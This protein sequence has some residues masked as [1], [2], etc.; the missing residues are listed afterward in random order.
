MTVKAPM[1]SSEFFDTVAFSLNRA[2]MVVGSD[3]GYQENARTFI[4]RRITTNEALIVM[5][6]G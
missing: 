1:R 6:S 2:P 4:K 3:L 5:P